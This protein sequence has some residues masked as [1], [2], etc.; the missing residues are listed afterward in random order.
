MSL[1]DRFGLILEDFDEGEWLIS[2]LNCTPNWN[3]FRLISGSRQT[4]T[5]TQ[6]NRYQAVNEQRTM[7]TAIG[8][9][10][11]NNKSPAV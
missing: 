11:L 10:Y 6:N 7:T 8:S 3:F 1:N 9:V 2:C 4:V 5:L